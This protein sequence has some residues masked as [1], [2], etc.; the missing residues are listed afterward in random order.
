MDQDVGSSVNTRFFVNTPALYAWG[1]KPTTANF[2]VIY[3]HK[4]PHRRHHNTFR[5]KY[6]H[7]LDNSKKTLFLQ[8]E[9]MSLEHNI[10][11]ALSLYRTSAFKD[12][13][14]VVLGSHSAYGRTLCRN[15][16]GL[17]LR[18]VCLDTGE[19]HP[20]TLYARRPLHSVDVRHN[21]KE[22]LH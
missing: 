19:S 5:Q 20:C 7:N 16:G 22:L 4:R 12:F 13:F 18:P 11:R 6:K 15:S 1:L 10:L 9:Y 17:H 21:T 8:W 3:I 14:K 2:Q